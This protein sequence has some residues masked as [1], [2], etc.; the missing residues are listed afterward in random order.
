MNHANHSLGLTFCHLFTFIRFG[1][2]RSKGF[3]TSQP[4]PLNW[5]LTP[6]WSAKAHN[7]LFI[8]LERRDEDSPRRRT[9]FLFYYESITCK[10]TSQIWNLGAAQPDPSGWI[11]WMQGS[12]RCRDSTWVHH[13]LLASLN[14]MARSHHNG[15]SRLEKLSP[16]ERAIVNNYK[17]L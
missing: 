9:R 7:R 16:H 15:P 2:A 12:S 13:R 5:L 10:Y 8:L 14:D 17:G 6:Y 3:L 11:A 1:L 4:R